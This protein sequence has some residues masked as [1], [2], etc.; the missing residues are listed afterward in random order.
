MGKYE[1]TRGMTP[2]ETE[3]L[4]RSFQQVTKPVPKQNNTKPGNK[5]KKKKPL[6]KKQA[7]R[8]RKILIISICAAVFLLLVGVIAWMIATM[9]TNEDD[10]RILSNV[11]AGSINLGGMTVD[12]AK[13]ALHL[14]TDSTFTQKDMIIRL[15]DDSIVLSPTNT[16]AKLDVDAVVEAAY[17][18]GRTGSD[19]EREQLQQS[20]AVYTIA[21]LPYLNLDLTYIQGTIADFCASYSSVMT[22]PTVTLEGERP[23]FDPEQPDKTVVH[24]VLS[25]TLGTPDYVLNEEDL[26][27]RVLDAYSLN[28]LSVTYEA[29]ALT[30]PDR[31]DAQ[32]L[33]AQYCVPAQDAAIDEVTFEVTPEVYGYGF[34]V[35]ELNQTISQAE[36]GQTIKVELDFIVPHITQK[37]LSGELFLD[38]LA[39]YVSINKT[40][41]STNRNTNLRLSCDTLD[42]YVIKDGE[43][44]SFNTILG[45]LTAEKGYKKAPAIVGG[46]EVSTLGGGVSQTAS[47]LYYCALL[48]DLEILERHNHTYAVTFVPLGFDANVEWGSKDLRF[49]NNTGNPLRIEASASDGTVSIELTGTDGLSYKV[50]LQSQIVTELLPETIYQTMAKDNILGYKDGDVLVEPITGYVVDTTMNR[51]DKA[52]GALLTS[53]SIDTAHYSKRDKQVVAIEPEPIIPTDPIL[54]TS[55]IDPPVPTDPV[56][57]TD[58]SAPTDPVTPTDPADPTEPTDP[59]V[60][61]E[62]SEPS[63]PTDP[64]VPEGPTDPE[65]TDPVPENP[66]P[67]EPETGIGDESP[68]DESAAA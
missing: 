4:E 12:E 28:Q 33:F 36:Y 20:G 31:P 15:P 23:E 13:S 1:N 16:G 66:Q 24:Q 50:D 42:G 67:S 5:A 54:P 2:R 56:D 62:P 49:R 47:A 65:V 60:P 27:A 61:S 44:F 64:T 59:S 55:P 7:A 17:N 34:D 68:S 11:Y 8:N 14:A 58:P 43:E 40:G 32:K 6:T 48:A 38:T 25:I 19:S 22:Q 3:E 45:R 10:G 37:D 9:D 53:K 52:T 26:Y 39:T 30:E 51:L 57:P 41:N 29:P 63:V 18:Y 21:L 35:E 46:E